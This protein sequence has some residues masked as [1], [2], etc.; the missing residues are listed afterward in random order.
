MMDTIGVEF[1]GIHIYLDILNSWNMF[2]TGKGNGFVV[3]YGLTVTISNGATFQFTYFPYVLNGLLKAEFSLPHI[4]F[5]NNIQMV[6]NIER[7]IN[8]AN[9][10]L[11]SVPGLPS[12][13]LWQGTL[14]RLDVCYLQPL[15]F[16]RR[17]TRPYTNQGVQ[18]GSGASTLKFY[19]KERER[20]DK[21]DE[22]GALLACGILRQEV[23]LR[24][25]A[26]KKLTGKKQ[27]T[28]YDI[29]LEMLLDVLERELQ[30]HGL[31]GHPIGTYD[32]TLKQ[33]CETYGTDAGFCYFGA[34]AANVEYPS[35]DTVISDSS[36]HPRTMDRRLN[37]VLSA[38][39][40]MTMTK[41][42]KPLPALNIDRA[43]VLRQT[44][45]GG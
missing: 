24:R 3:K 42:E 1:A 33:L 4:V 18:Y 36:M 30:Q 26:I 38:G 25:K 7:A 15:K 2:R 11:P 22:I 8:L 13:D 39:L 20:H 32:S 10:K 31:L 28:L 23:V 21:G 12:L 5:G 35:R 14:C 16:S 41:A 34:L 19:D 37:K 40:T 27:P 44:E 9:Q 29:T 17:Q 43:W 6:F 45:E